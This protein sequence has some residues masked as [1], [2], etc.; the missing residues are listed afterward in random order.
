MHHD[1]WDHNVLR[2]GF[3]KEFADDINA[4]L[5]ERSREIAQRLIANGKL[6]DEDIAECSGISVEDVV[7][8]RSQMFGSDKK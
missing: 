8:L 4:K 7:V 2:R 6:P 1:R 3:F 5:D